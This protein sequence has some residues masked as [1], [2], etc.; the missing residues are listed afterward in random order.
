MPRK[1]RF[2][3]SGVPAH[4]IQRGNNRQPIF[5]ED[6]DY[7]MYLSLVAE[8]CERYGSA[9]HTYVLMTNHVHLLATPEDEQSLSRVMQY[10]GRHF[11][12]YI[13]KKYCRSGTLWEGR[14]RA[15]T[16]DSSNYLLACYRYIE[17]NPVRAG[18]VDTPG[19]YAWSGFHRNA[20]GETDKLI[21]PHGEYLNLGSAPS[22]RTQNYRL[23]FDHPVS[24]LELKTI[25]DFV[26][27]G[28]PLGSSQFQEKVEMMLSINVGKVGRGRPKVGW[29]KGSDP[30]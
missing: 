26:Q 20:L 12:P 19:E 8:A 10:I 7:Q 14:F 13:N 1:R 23:L 21:T 29:K 25:R 3:V 16:I 2:F 4:L 15:S 28:T 11:V 27:S 30:F 22:T 9:V 24:N 17:M 5:F 6:T 18:M